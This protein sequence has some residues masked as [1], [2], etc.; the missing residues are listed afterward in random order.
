[1]ISTPDSLL[2]DWDDRKVHKVDNIDPV[3]RVSTVM[4]ERDEALEAKMLKRYEVANKYYQM[5][6]NELKNK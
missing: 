4:I 3:R 6:L 1:M 5:Y 2:K